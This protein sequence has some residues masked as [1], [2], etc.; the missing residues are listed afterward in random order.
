MKI[1]CINSLPAYGNAG[2]KCALA[3]LQTAAVPVPSLVLS[4]LGNL[5]GHQRFPYPFA[6]NLA[7]TLQHLSDH[8][9]NFAVSIGYLGSADQPA[10]IAE[11]LAG[12]RSQIQGILIDPV[13]GDQGRAYV[14]EELIANW[15]HLLALADWATP[16]AT[17]ALL[18]GGHPNLAEAIAALQTRY[19]HTHWV[20]TSYPLG[21]QKISNR[22]Y[23]PQG[24]ADWPQT[25]IS[26]QISGAG[27]AFASFLAR[28]LFL[29]KQPPAA[30]L[31]ASTLLTYQFILDHLLPPGRG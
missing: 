28:S 24:W 2:L 30:A 10:Q 21:Q 17:E 1:L 25:Q 3:I 5:P 26:G 31:D 27:D 15:S 4:G 19:P 6:A 9:P 14:S 12:R 23:H 7:A 16:N 13:C 11:L 22:W 20:V 18:L 8:E 29:E